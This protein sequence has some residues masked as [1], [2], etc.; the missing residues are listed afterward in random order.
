MGRL[1]LNCAA[2]KLSPLPPRRLLPRLSLFFSPQRRAFWLGAL[3]LALLEC[4]ASRVRAHFLPGTAFFQVPAI[5]LGVAVIKGLVFGPILGLLTLKIHDFWR[6]QRWDEA[7]SL[8]LRG[9]FAVGAAPAFFALG[10]F[11]AR[12][13]FPKLAWLAQSWLGFGLWLTLNVSL[14]WAL[15]LVV[16]GFLLPHDARKTI[17]ISDELRF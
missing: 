11:L 16:A 1:R 13:A 4:L 2:L 12:G 9:G 8:C 3:F 7:C 6:R 17:Q 14:I 15:A 5:Y 10:C